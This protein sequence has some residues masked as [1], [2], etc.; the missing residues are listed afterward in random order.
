MTQL[1]HSELSRKIIG[2]AMEVLN[3]LGPGQ[4]EKVYERAVEIELELR[5]SHVVRQRQYAVTYKGHPIGTFIPD[6]LIDDLV[7]VDPKVV[8]SFNENHIAQMLG[9]LAVSGLK[10][11]LLLN[12]K[13][14][15]LEWKRVVASSKAMPQESP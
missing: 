1:E 14:A 11:A 9:Y 3:A 4:D 12:F 15:R 2:A 10:L 7:L 5:G 13:H 8:T 6:M